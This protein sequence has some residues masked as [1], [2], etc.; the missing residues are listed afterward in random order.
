[1]GLELTA[2]V[3]IGTDCTG[4]CISN[5]HTIKAMTSPLF[6]INKQRVDNRLSNIF[7]RQKSVIMLFLTWRT[8]LALKTTEGSK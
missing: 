2:L 3:V 7:I 8:T 1:M 6:F 4:S 5:Y